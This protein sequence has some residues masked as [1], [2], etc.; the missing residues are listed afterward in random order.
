MPRGVPVWFEGWIISS[1]SDRLRLQENLKLRFD[2]DQPEKMWYP[3]K[4]ASRLNVAIVLSLGVLVSC[5]GQGNAPQVRNPDQIGEP[6]DSSPASI[7]VDILTSRFYFFSYSPNWGSFNRGRDDAALKKA[8]DSV[9]GQEG[10]KAFIKAFATADKSVNVLLDENIL[11][12]SAASGKIDLVNQTRDAWRHACT[13]GILPPKLPRGNIKWTE[14]ELDFNL[15]V[16][17]D[18]EGYLVVRSSRGQVMGVFSLYLDGREGNH[19]T[20]HML[21]SVVLFPDHHINYPWNIVMATDTIFVDD[22]WVELDRVMGTVLV[23]ERH[24]KKAVVKAPD[25]SE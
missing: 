19:I 4:S 3:M 5:R 16:Q 23:G 22:I 24:Q 13:F 7:Q 8:F 9:R 14:S 20:R 6:E 15:L 2:P 21:E 18:S 17:K 12:W 11:D 1:A 10:Y 25:S